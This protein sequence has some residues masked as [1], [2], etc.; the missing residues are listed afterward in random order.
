[1]PRRPHRVRYDPLTRAFYVIS[2][3]SQDIYKLVR[4]NG[5]L[6]KLYK[7]HLD[8]LGGKYTR[9]ITL[10]DGAMYFVSGPGFIYKAEYRDD[11]FKVLAKYRVPEGM[12]SANDL[13]RTADGWWYLTATDLKIIRVRNLEHLAAGRF[14]DVSAQ[15]GMHGTP[16][17]LSRI[18]GRYYIPII[19]KRSAILSF[20][21]DGGTISDVQVLCDFGAPNKVDKKRY[22]EL[23]R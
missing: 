3:D 8:F 21:H 11:S 20:V 16:Y 22:K 12:A 4:N 18:D 6:Q 19:G 5:G 7:K 15:L 2:A 14:E 17:Y 10:A 13:F 1:M 9:S 23:P